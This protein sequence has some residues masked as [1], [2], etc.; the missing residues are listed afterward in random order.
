MIGILGALKECAGVLLGPPQNTDKTTLII[1]VRKK[2]KIRNCK[3]C[4]QNILFEVLSHISLASLLW[5]I[6]AN[7]ENPNLLKF[8]PKVCCCFFFK[9]KKNSQ[10][11]LKQKWADPI[12]NGG[13]FN[14]A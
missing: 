1:N 10:H 9:K 6:W 3:I 5:D 4:F 12:D 8:E 7:I 11:P 2:A 14:L 13:E